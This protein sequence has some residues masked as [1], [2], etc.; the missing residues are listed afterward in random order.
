MRPYP[1][2]WLATAT[3]AC[4]LSTGAVAQSGQA[5]VPDDATLEAAGARIGTIT[6]RR[7]PIFDPNIPGERRKL[8]R[9]ADKLH[10]DTRESVIASQLLFE[11]G[12]P[13][14]R[15]LL[16]ETERNLRRVRYL[17]EPDIRVVGWHDGVVDLEVVT[18]EVWT[19]NLGL[20][21][22]RAGGKNTYGAEL[23]ELNL[24]GYGKHL[25]FDWED[26]VERTFYGVQWIDQN[27]A[28]T[29]W[30]DMLWL[31]DSDDGKGHTLEIERPFYM[32]DARWST[33]ITIKRDDTIEKVYR[34]GIRESDYGRVLEEGELRYGWSAGL[35]DGWARRWIAGLHH[36]NAAFAP[37]TGL[38]APATL[39]G[40]RRLDYPFLR[41]E[42]VQD[43]FEA[44]TH[45]DQISRTEDL[46][47]GTRYLAELGWSVEEFG[48]D[49]DAAIFR[50][51]A[52]RG[53]RLGER[54]ALFA[55]ASLRGRLESGTPA[56]ALA[57]VSVQY[58][59][60][61][62]DKRTFLISFKGEAGHDLDGDRLLPLGGDEGLRGYPYR[63]QTGESRALLTLEQRF[64]TDYSLWRIADIGAAIFFD[65]GQSWGDSLTGPGARRG[66]LKDVG[67]GLRLSNR[68][69]GLGNVTHFD[70]AFPLDGDDSIDDI[71]FLV[72]T[73]TSF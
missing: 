10:I 25:S 55:S 26:G 23:E 13:F 49:R 27:V 30:R 70:I 65:A 51:E 14:S 17:R 61:N 45:Y 67:F 36:E 9:L 54:E 53:F 11:S 5:P 44:R 2:T 35:R 6:Y 22:H 40:D 28:G 63:Y 4:C 42:A 8:F 7:L 57:A 71:Q 47:F 15:R 19:T 73:R 62:G 32:L 33:G 18:Q 66:L 52:S 60:P 56:D 24:L 59:R 50:A 3:V 41:F 21:F 29:R 43:D 37:V 16:D 1:L 64:Y 34:L 38:A 58:Y 48:A 68:R 39:P 46:H 12:D 20:A 72:T 31:R 69:S